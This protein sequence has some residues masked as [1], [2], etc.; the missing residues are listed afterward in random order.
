MKVAFAERIVMGEK[1]NRRSGRVTLAVL[2]LTFILPFAI[3]VYQLVAEVNQ[4]VEF[5]QAELYGNAYL[6]PLM[7]LLRDVSTSAQQPY[8][9]SRLSPRYAS[10][11]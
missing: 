8:F 5:A 4:R 3:V 9:N 11:C 6:R 1:P 7:Q 2:L 10:P